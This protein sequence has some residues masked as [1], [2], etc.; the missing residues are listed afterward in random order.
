MNSEIA[1]IH[2]TVWQITSAVLWSE[3]GVDHDLCLSEHYLLGSSYGLYHILYVPASEYYYAIVLTIY[4][5][6]CL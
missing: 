2:R 4:L 1:I 6:V 3:P 5:S